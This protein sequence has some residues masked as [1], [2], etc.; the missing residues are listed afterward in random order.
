MEASKHWYCDDLSSLVASMRRTCPRRA[1]RTLSNRTMRLPVIEIAD[2]LGQ[3]L[4]QMALI[5][6]EYVV[7]ALRPDRSHPALGDGVGPRRSERR[8]SLGNTET[9]HPLIEPGAVTVVAV[10]NEKT[11]RLVVPTAAFDD[12]LCRPLGGRM[13]R[14]MHVENL[15]AGVMDHEEDV[16]CPKEDRLDAEKSHAQI[17]AACCFRN[18]RQPGDGLG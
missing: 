9:T 15:P 2:I 6:D 16:E 18:N 12:L 5:E 8:A 3:N 11:W 13:R 7:Q 14:H 10:M 1:G 17:V 4:R